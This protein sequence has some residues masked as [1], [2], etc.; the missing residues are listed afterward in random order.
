ME[1]MDISGNGVAFI[2]NFEGFE[3]ELYNDPGGN[4]SIGYGHLVHTGPVDGTEPRDWRD[5]ITEK[6][7]MVLLRADLGNAVGHVRRMVKVPLTQ[8]QFDTLVSFVFNV[9]QGNFARSDLLAA[10]NRGEYDRVPEELSRWTRAGGTRY[11]GLVKRRDQEGQL[12]KHGDYDP[13]RDVETEVAPVTPVPQLPKPGIAPSTK[14]RGLANSI[15]TLP[16]T[17]TSSTVWRHVPQWC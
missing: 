7:A 13:V 16:R 15:S 6:E 11:A 4:A 1:P 12:W 17:L 3:P 9:G 8:H 10:L 2:A 5:G 14:C